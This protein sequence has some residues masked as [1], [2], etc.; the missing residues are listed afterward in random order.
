MT[1]HGVAAV[2]LFFWLCGPTVCLYS[3]LCVASMTFLGQKSIPFLVSATVIFD[4]TFFYENRKEI[5]NEI[6][7]RQ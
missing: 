3:V 7:T 5:F 6:L 1:N 4:A 2:T